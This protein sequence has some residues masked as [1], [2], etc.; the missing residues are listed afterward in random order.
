MFETKLRNTIFCTFNCINI[1]NKLNFMLLPE[2]IR[3]SINIVLQI[4]RFR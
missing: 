2:K 3:L 1:Y 4:K